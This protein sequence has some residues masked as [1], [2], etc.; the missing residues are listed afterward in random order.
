MKSTLRKKYLDLRS[1]EE[2]HEDKSLK[3]CHGLIEYV[4]EQKPGKVFSFSSYGSEVDLNSFHDYLHNEGLSVFLPRITSR[5]G[6]MEFRIWKRTDKLSKNSYGILEPVVTAEVAAPDS[7]SLIVVP[8]LSVDKKGVRLGYGGG[9]YD[10]YISN[11]S[12][13]QLIVPIFQNQITEVLPHDDHDILVDMAITELGL[14][15]F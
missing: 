3:I 15:N 14:L 7:D 11:H 6:E 8:A 1:R 2:H 4:K 9:F 10:R 5:K 12:N 13:K